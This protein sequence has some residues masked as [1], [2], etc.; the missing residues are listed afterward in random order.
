MRFH[1]MKF[2][3][4]WP[5]KWVCNGNASIALIA[6]TAYAEFTCHG[7]VPFVRHVAGVSHSLRCDL[8]LLEAAI[9]FSIR[10]LAAI[11]WETLCVAFYSPR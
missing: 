5:D 3:G 6:R 7:I 10:T 9:P 1:A 11:R 2:S 4:V 8:E